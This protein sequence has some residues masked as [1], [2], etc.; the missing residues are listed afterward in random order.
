MELFRITSIKRKQTLIIMITSGAALLLACLAFT[1]FDFFTFRRDMVGDLATHAQ[2][3][4]NNSTAGLDFNDPKEVEDTLAALRADSYIQGAAVYTK[5]GRVF[6]SYDRPDDGKRFSPPPVQP[7]GYRFTSKALLMFRPIVRKGD[8]VGTVFVQSDLQELYT[9]MEEYVAIA[10]GVFSAAG[11]VAFG[12]SNRLQRIVSLPILHLVETARSVAREQNYS[13][14]AIRQSEDELGVLVDSFNEMLTEIQHRDAQ[15]Q[16]AKDSL[17]LR[18]EERTRELKE[19]TEELHQEVQHHKRTEQALAVSERLM[20]SLVETL[21]QN[22]LRKDLDGRFT[23]VNGFFCRTVGKPKEEILGKTDFDLFPAELASKYRGDDQQVI[24]NGKPI[25]TEE[26]HR[27]PN[28]QRVFVQVIKTPLYDAE[29]KSIGLQVIFWD[30][31]ARRQA[32]QALRTQE[33]RTRS[34]IDQAFDSAVTTD[35]EGRIIGWNRQAQATFGWTPAQV[36]GRKLTETLV[37]VRNRSEREADFERFCQTGKWR[38]ENQLFETTG[39]HQDGHEIPVEVSITPIRVGNGCIFNAFLRDISARKKAE[40]ELAYERDLLK[41]LLD[42]SPE[43]IYFKDLESRFVRFSKSCARLFHLPDA[44]TIRGKTDFDFFTE[45]DARPFFEDEQQIIRTGKPVLGKVERETHADG[46]VSWAMTSK[47]PWRDGTGKIIGTFGI[48]Q[49]ITSIKEAEAKLEAVN[50]QLIDASR[51]A[52]MAEVA[53]SVLHNV[54]N[55]LN[56]IN[57]TATLVE[58][59]V[60][61]S[62]GSDLTRLVKLLG[63]HAADLGEFFTH[64]PR[65]QKV[66]EF[67]H[68]LCE[69]LAGEQALVLA[70]LASLRKNIEHIKDIVAMQQSYAKISGVVETVRVAD[71]VEDTLRMNAGALARHDVRVIREYGPVTPISTDKHKV[72][73]ILINVV[74]NAKDACDESG[75]SDKQIIVKVAESEDRVRISIIDNGVG[76]QPE[77]L[78]RIFNH[79]FTTRKNGHGFGLHSGALAAKELGGALIVHSDGPGKGA[80]FTLELPKRKLPSPSTLL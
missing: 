70:E 76:I 31:T 75:R 16:K 21:P 17:E 5:E 8:T 55:V 49:N 67:L 7:P 19:R 46:Q 4:G 10:L 69:R 40:A 13:R 41:T 78:T 66:P 74:R 62:R 34:I 20:V 27:I 24:S 3:I 6:A 12:L 68:H 47:L 44:E 43:V 64:D 58:D 77:N 32:E 61:K 29:Q 28:G 37:P 36:M 22:V 51:Q 2:I 33:E 45:Q 1:I 53:T 56:S 35:V 80:S 57:V 18:V 50:R 39:V 79:G 72:L 71:L 48:S 54:G 52:G 25:K 65:G 60:R 14:R 26:E 42:N 63:D 23:F 59:R 11:L 38:L 15:L 73:Q 9:R 30:V